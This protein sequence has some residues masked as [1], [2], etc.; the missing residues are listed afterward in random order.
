MSNTNVGKML[1]VKKL[2]NQSWYGVRYLADNNVLV[3]SEYHENE[4][5]PYVEPPSKNSP[6]IISINI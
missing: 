1:L 3:Y 2:P 4:L 6:D 5:E